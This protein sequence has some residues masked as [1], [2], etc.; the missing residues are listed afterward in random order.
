MEESK[1][2]ALS[3]FTLES[4]LVVDSRYTDPPIRVRAIL[5]T[6]CAKTSH[7]FG[8]PRKHLEFPIQIELAQPHSQLLLERCLRKR[9]YDDHSRSAAQIGNG[10]HRTH[11]ALIDQVFKR[12]VRCALHRVAPQVQL[13]NFAYRRSG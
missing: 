3:C 7:E 5:I 1:T 8:S 13:R 2:P 4:A 10:F 6:I 12:F 9:R 11:R